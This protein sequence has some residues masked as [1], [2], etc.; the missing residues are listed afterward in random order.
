MPSLH[1][2]QPERLRQ[3]PARFSWVDHRLVRE[4][5]VE[6]CSTDALAL[7]LFLLTVADPKGL[8]YYSQPSLMKRLKMD[9]THFTQ[10]RSELIQAR[11]IAYQHPLY[12]VLSLA[13]DL[14]VQDRQPNPSKNNPAKAQIATPQTT[15]NTA[16]SASEQSASNLAIQFIRQHL[17]MG[18]SHD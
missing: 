12:Q 9:E 10:S 6:R 7:Y 3:I 2:P 14:R 5:Y 18:D 11:L 8:S 16:K 1:I 17:S 13:P 4:H 15:Q